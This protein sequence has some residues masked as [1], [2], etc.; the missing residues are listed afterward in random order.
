MML[1]YPHD[2]SQIIV[3]EQEFVS[4]SVFKA[5]RNKSGYFLSKQEFSF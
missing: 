3:L 4:T 2:S 1:E 5:I